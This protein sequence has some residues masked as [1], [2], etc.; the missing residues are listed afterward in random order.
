[1]VAVILVGNVQLKRAATGHGDDC[2]VPEQLVPR[3]ANPGAHDPVIAH[4][5]TNHAAGGEQPP[6]QRL[7]G[8]VQLRQFVEELDHLR[9]ELAQHVRSKQPGVATGCQEREQRDGQGDCGEATPIG[10]PLFLQH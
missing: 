8:L 1:M 5:R 4:A 2:G 7:I 9:I 10:H 3:H 6:D